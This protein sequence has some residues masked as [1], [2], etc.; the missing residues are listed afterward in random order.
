MIISTL[1]YL[2][3]FIRFSYELNNG[4]GRTPQMGKIEKSSTV[5]EKSY[6]KWCTFLLFIEGWNSWNNIHRN[7]NETVVRDTADAIVA[8]GLAE[9]GYQYGMYSV[10][11]YTYK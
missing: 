5:E 6:A 2:F 8:T 9:A 7:I 3:I 1:A 11:F 4:L 10:L